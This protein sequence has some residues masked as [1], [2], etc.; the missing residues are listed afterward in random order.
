MNPVAT[1]LSATAQYLQVSASTRPLV[2]LGSKPQARLTNRNMTLADDGSWADLADI[3]L[4]AIDRNRSK[5]R[6]RRVRVRGYILD[7]ASRLEYHRTLLETLDTLIGRAIENAHW[8]SLLTC[9]AGITD[10]EAHC[11]LHFAVPVI[12]GWRSTPRTDW[13]DEVWSWRL[14]RPH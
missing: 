11:H 14:A 6:K 1:A 4:T 12:D 3:V 8:C 10:G 5:A 13:I 9:R 2:A 7:Q